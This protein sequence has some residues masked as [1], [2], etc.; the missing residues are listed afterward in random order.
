[1]TQQGGDRLAES[2]DTYTMTYN[3]SDNSVDPATEGMWVMIDGD[4]TVDT[5]DDTNNDDLDAVIGDDTAANSKGEVVLRGIVKARVTSGVTGGD[6]LQPAST[7]GVATN[8]GSSGYKA[9]T[10]AVEYPSGSSEYYSYV[11]LE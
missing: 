11:R 4:L 10:D 5:A 7:A 6:E 3:N 1:M 8:G 9:L 2:G